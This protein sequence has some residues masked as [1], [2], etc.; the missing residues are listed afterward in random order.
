MDFDMGLLG[1]KSKEVIGF[2]KY[3]PGLIGVFFR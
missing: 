1:I 3:S 2:K